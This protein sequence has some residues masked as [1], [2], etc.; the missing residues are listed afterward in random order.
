[1]G[2]INQI[3]LLD[4]IHY[5]IEHKCTGTPG[6]FAKRIGVSTSKLY[7]ILAE[8][9][10]GGVEI[11]YD[12]ERNSYVYSGNFKIDSLVALPGHSFKD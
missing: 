8:L 5:K 4:N 12:N 3:Q 11:R 9:R 2:I 6:D 7:R 1:M 10:D